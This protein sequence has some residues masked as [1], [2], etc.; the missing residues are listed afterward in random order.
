MR[1]HFSTLSIL[2][3]A[4]LAAISFV[5]CDFKTDPNPD[6][7]EGLYVYIEPCMDWTSDKNQTREYTLSLGNDWEEVTNGVGEDYLIFVNNT[8]M[9][10]I[11]YTFED[12]ILLESSVLYL[13]NKEFDRM[14]SDWAGKFSLTWEETTVLG[15]TAYKAECSA[16]QSLMLAQKGSA[17]G[18]NYMIMDICHLSEE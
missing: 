5:S 7:I 3:A 9:V 10:E 13:T 14:K 12:D 16:K 18:Y 1:K 2:L 4:T 8:L 11:D 6:P 15:A 17:S